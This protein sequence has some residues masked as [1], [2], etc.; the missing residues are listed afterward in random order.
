MKPNTTFTATPAQT[1]TSTPTPSPTPEPG[2]TVYLRSTKLTGT[3]GTLLANGVSPGGGSSVSIAKTKSLTWVNKPAT[4]NALDAG[5]YSV[6]LKRQNNGANSLVAASVDVGY[7]DA[8]ATFVSLSTGAANIAIAKNGVA[9]ASLTLTARS[10]APG[11]FLAI[12][13]TDLD[14]TS[15]IAISTNGSSFLSGPMH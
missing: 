13:V 14:P 10:L 12:R 7:C 5:D 9:S 15:S 6:T 8:T 2:S 4:I 3:C 1:A 11:E